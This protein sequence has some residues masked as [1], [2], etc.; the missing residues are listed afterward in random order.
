MKFYDLGQKDRVQALILL[1]IPWIVWQ[2]NVTLNIVAKNMK[3]I[4]KNALSISKC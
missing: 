1:R 3:L 4:S 2:S